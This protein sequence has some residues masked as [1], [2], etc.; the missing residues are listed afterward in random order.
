[1]FIN[2]N[3]SRTEADD[4]KLHV[5]PHMSKNEWAEPV[6]SDNQLIGWKLISAYE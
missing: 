4:F 6:Y 2:R 5:Q 3:F 1:M